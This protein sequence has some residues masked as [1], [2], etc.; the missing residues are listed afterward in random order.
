MVFNA[1]VDNISVLSWRLVLLVEET[2]LPGENHQLYHIMLSRVHIAMS[3]IR[4]HSF[5]GDSHWLY[6]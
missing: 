2:G 3:G 4:T 6:R 1:T 5:S